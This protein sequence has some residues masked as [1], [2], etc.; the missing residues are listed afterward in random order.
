MDKVTWADLVN[1]KM[2]FFSVIIEAL[3][4]ILV[5]VFVSSVLNL[6]LSEELIQ[7]LLP[8]NR[9]LGIIIASILGILLPLCECG[10][11]PVTRRLVQKGVPVSV[12][13][14]FMLAT[15]II[16]PVVLLA[17]SVAF[18]LN[19]KMV[20]LRLG[21][22][23]L[24]SIVTGIVLSFVLKDNQLKENSDLHCDCCSG[25][26][27]KSDS[28]VGNLFYLLKGACSEFFEMGK[29]LIAGAFL[30][31]IA[32]TTIPYSSLSTVGQA[33]FLSIIVMMVFA[34]FVS[35]CS[36]ADAFIAASF[37]SSFT[38]GALIAFMVFGPMIDLKN[39]LMLYHS[40][41]LRFVLTLII[42]AVFLCVSLSYLSNLLVG[43]V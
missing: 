24:V 5:G 1:F 23:F 27:A 25:H 39:T 17:T 8:Q 18:S 20:W 41:R 14:T 15:P 26:M 6:F 4:F 16:N 42:V 31:A 10:I 32:Q 3:P 43:G 29:F 38:T 36:S 11:V 40:F 28:I 13:A 33:P 2:I 34:F 19:P 21:V 37:G 12:A 22:A 7:K 35:V 9:V 30:S